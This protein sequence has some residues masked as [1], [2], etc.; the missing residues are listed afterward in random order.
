MDIATQRGS[1]SPKNEGKQMNI[2]NS[3]ARTNSTLLFSLCVSS[4][5]NQYSNG[6]SSWRGEGEREREREN[7]QSILDTARAVCHGEELPSAAS[8][9]R[10][11]R[12]P[13]KTSDVQA[14]LVLD[15]YVQLFLNFISF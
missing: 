12:Q 10:D 7:C 8:A 11:N 14:L 15:G 9:N 6:D 2:S 4:C 3:I 5:S 1:H 13:C